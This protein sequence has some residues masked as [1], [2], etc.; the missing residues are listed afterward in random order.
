[1]RRRTI[2]LL[3]SIAGVV[4]AVVLAVAGTYFYQR[5]D[6]AETTVRDQLRAQNIFFPPEDALS[7]SEREQPGVV[8]IVT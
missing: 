2:D 1:M 5:Y 6:F 7:E 3:A 4:A 8:Q